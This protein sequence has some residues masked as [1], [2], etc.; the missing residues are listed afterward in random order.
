[1]DPRVKNVQ[2]VGSSGTRFFFL[3]DLVATAVSRTAT[4]DQEGRIH[5]LGVA[6]GPKTHLTDRKKSLVS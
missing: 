5:H 1:L 2:M 4:K 3:V 6:V